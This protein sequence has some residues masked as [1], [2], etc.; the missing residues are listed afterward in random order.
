MG[1]FISEFDADMDD[2]D[3]TESIMFKK[4]NATDFSRQK[5]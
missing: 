2:D 5:V 1:S 4:E 3:A